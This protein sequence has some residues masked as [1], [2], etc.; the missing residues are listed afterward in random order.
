MPKSAANWRSRSVS[1]PRGAAAA[2][3]LPRAVA[4]LADADLFAANLGD[5]GAAEPAEARIAR[6]IA[7]R[8][9]KSDEDDETEGKE[10]ADRRGKHGADGGNHGAGILSGRARV[11]RDCA[12]L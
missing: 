7:E 2:V 5:V 4:Q 12:L 10:F 9:G 1:A 6:H 8:E 11:T 3:S